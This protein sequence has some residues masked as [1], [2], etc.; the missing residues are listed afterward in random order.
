MKWLRVL[1]LPPDAKNTGHSLHLSAAQG[2]EQEYRAT[3]E[4]QRQCEDVEAGWGCR[5]RIRGVSIGQIVYAAQ[6]GD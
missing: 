1:F 6:V 3:G 2:V 5:A 4:T